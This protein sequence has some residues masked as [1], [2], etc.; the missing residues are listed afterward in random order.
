VRL[1]S[2]DQIELAAEILKKGELVAFPTETVYGLGAPIFNAQAVAKI[3]VAKGRP[4]DNPLIAH[5]V[6]LEQVEEIAC[7]IPEEFYILAQAFFPGPLTLVLKRHPQVPP[8]VSGGLETIAVR[9][10]SHPIARALILS[11]GEP[12]VA[13]SANLS[14][15]P[16]STSAEHVIVDFQGKIGAVIDGGKTEYG[17]ESTVISLVSSTPCLLRQGALKKEAIEKILGKPIHI[18]AFE[19]QLASPGTRYR[20]YAP[21]AML[22]LFTSQD[23]LKRATALPARRLILDG[24]D[25]PGLYA[26]LRKADDEKYEEIFLYCSP[27]MAQE[28]ALMDRLQR[29]ACV[30]DDLPL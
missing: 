1:L 7:D 15:K 6:S 3:Y 28:A 23:E 5:I 11:V 8:I 20:H 16:S 26:M 19:E 30:S 25:A 12:L 27:A 2:P 24:I 9:M 22:K 17:I 18:G 21:K 14:G 4:S 10:P 29:I 13:P